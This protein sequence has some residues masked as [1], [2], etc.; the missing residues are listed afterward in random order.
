VG[1]KPVWRLAHLEP[2][3]LRP[4]L[5]LTAKNPLETID[6]GSFAVNLMYGGPL[7]VALEMLKWEPQKITAYWQKG[8]ICRL[9]YELNSIPS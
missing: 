4:S 5:N 9:C 3:E 7:W 2:P 1:L 6:P 8:D